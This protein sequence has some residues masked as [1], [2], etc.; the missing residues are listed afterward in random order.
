MVSTIIA[1]GVMFCY[2]L[3]QEEDESVDTLCLVCCFPK[4]GLSGTVPGFTDPCSV[5]ISVVD[6]SSHTQRPHACKA[7]TGDC[8]C[9]I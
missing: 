7:K 9:R 1:I 6:I 4:Q 5:V 2:L 8:V 3:Q